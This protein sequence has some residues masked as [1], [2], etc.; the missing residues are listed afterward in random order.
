MRAATLYREGLTLVESVHDQ[1]GLARCLEGLA[2]V[3]AAQAQ[4][5]RA[6]RLGGSA[7]ARRAALGVPLP[8]SARAAFEGA[9]AAARAALGED[10]FATAWA[11]G[12]ALS[13]EQAIAEA[14]HEAEMVSS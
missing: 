13:T 10:A 1:V 2:T 4:G 6:A 7:A 8:P 11:A 3:A 5:L 9:M 12:Q 14:I